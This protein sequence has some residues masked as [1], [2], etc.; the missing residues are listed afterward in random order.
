MK[1]FAK[2]VLAA[3]FVSVAFMIFINFIYFFPWYMTIIYETFNLTQIAANDNYVKESYYND[4]LY[5]L[6]EKPMF[7][8][9]A[10][11]IEIIVLNDDGYTAIGN[12]DETIYEDSLDYE[13]PYKQRNSHLSVEIK[14]VYPLSV[15]LW[16]QKVE[17]EIPVSFSLK[18]TG[19]KHYKDLDYYTELDYYN[20]FGDLGE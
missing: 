19:L 1:G 2:A 16:G 8:E 13:K 3:I 11:K 7:R 18:T 14:A 6:K 4:I 17:R 12:D 15:T 5:R 10:E 9:K 20:S